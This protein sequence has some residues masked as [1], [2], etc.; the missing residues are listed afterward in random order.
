MSDCIRD[1]TKNWEGSDRNCPFTGGALFS[2]SNWNCGIVNR[3]R[4]LAFPSNCIGL[5]GI[6]HEFLDDSHYAIFNV[7][8]ICI[9]DDVWLGQALWI[10]WYKSR[11]ATMA[12]WLLDCEG[13]PRAPS[14]EELEAIADYYE[15]RRP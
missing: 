5:T 7:D 11:G 13:P 1:C 8:D 4:E 6:E 14:A 10:A 15:A 2:P 3:I 9:D 12:M